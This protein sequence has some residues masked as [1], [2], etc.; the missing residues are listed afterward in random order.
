MIDLTWEDIY[1]EAGKLA[2]RHAHKRYTGI[3]GI[4]Q[5][6]APVALVVSNYLQLPVLDE[7]ELGCLIVD[8]L[9]DS[10]A[11]AAKELNNLEGVEFD[12]LFRKEYS[13]THLAPEAFEVD[14]WI[15]F[16][17][18]RAKG[19]PQDAITRLLEYI[20]EDPTREGLLDTPKRVLKAFKEM[21]DGYNADIST[22][23]GTTFDVGDVDEMIV[24]TGIDFVS[25]CE[26]H[27]LPF[28]GTAT[29]AY[30][31]GER[32][33]GLSKIP[34][35]VEAFSHRLQVQERLT[36]Q[37]TRALDEH[38]GTQGSACLITS[39]HA[40]MGHRGV[41]KPN[42]KMTTSSLTG[43]FKTDADTRHEFLMLAK[44]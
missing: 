5:G 16:P 33:V 15:N 11:T 26:H 20:G 38:L 17:W 39:G 29:V 40:C 1:R 7:P 23:L 6:G 9:V 22:I 34:R 36:R 14:G 31:P 3:Y 2:N 32:V 19:E 42:A 30:I 41:K 37:I 24:V 27:M 35:I 43:L 8:D 12:A 4:P 10:G 28:T 18:E 44:D 21:T 13:P 25:L